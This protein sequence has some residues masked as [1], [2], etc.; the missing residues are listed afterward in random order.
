[1][2]PV[3][4]P[5]LP[6]RKRIDEY[7]DG[8][9]ERNWL[10]NNGPLVKEYELQLRSTL[11]LEK[12]LYVNN[13]TIALQI[14]IKG[15]ALQGEII[16]TPFSYIATTS[17]ILWEGARPVFVDINEATLNIDENQIEEAITEKTSGILAT[18]C[19]G[20]A[21]NIEKIEAIALKR[22]LK[23]IYDAA[24]CFG[25]EYKGKSIFSYGDVS[26]TSLHATKVI[27]SVEGGMIFSNSA[28]LLGKMAFMRNFGH[29]GP[30]KYA[31]IGING[32][33]SEFHA[34]VGLAVLNDAPAILA[35][36]K[37]Q[38]DYYKENLTG[39][40]A[41]IPVVQEY[42]EPNFSY[43]PL[44]FSS[45]EA[46]VEA[47]TSLEAVQIYPR[48]YFYPSLDTLDYLDNK[49]NTCPKSRDVSSRILCLPL[50]H[51]M[52][53]EVQDTIINTLLKN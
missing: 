48:R 10:T 41:R 25:T 17:S 4:K 13:G 1:M 18:H 44:I 30:E 35:K 24:H 23:V 38:F 53:V 36:R 20:N 40:D 3:T 14:A 11:G 51:E 50:F 15:L 29:D 34:A 21:C 16:T 49:D 31:E 47:K 9:F 28:E 32:K 42:C 43:F 5:Y 46:L 19:F 8:I 52:T 12:L 2:I 39:L 33:N 37:E 26:T 7:L 6:D 27:H 45:R 22:N